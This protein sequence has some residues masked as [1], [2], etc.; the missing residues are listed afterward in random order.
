MSV[1]KVR[2]FAEPP[3]ARAGGGSYR[4]GELKGII[5]INP[6]HCVGCDTCR[7]VCPAGAISGEIGITHRIEIDRCI[8]CGQ[9]LTNCPFGAIEQMAFV[10]EVLRK[11]GDK[12]TLTVAIIAPAVRVAIAEEFGAPPG[13]LTVGRLHKA[14]KEAGFV[15]YEN[16]FAAD[17]TILEEGT[18]LLGRIAYW[19]LGLKEFEIEVWGKKIKVGLEHFKHKP[20][21]QFTSCCPA[22]VRYA[23]L[24]Y[25]KV[26]PHVSS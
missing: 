12:E 25:P 24:Y 15:I 13:T 6:R 3:E 21:P 19:L 5:R 10:E 20:L 18:E 8:N 2:T 14:L 7:Q 23:E 16:N 9:C 22:W 1:A 4:T 17:Q 11:L 26:L